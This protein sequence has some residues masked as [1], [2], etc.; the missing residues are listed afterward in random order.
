MS[1]V[2]IVVCLAGM[3]VLFIVAGALLDS[4]TRRPRLLCACAVGGLGM[5]LAAFLLAKGGQL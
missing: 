5:L 2:L 1:D 3:A 4:K